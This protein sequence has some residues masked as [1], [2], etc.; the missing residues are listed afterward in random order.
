MSSSTLH[1]HKFYHRLPLQGQAFGIEEEA[2][3]QQVAYIPV[4]DDYQEIF[5]AGV[6]INIIEEILQ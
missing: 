6:S 5:L 3:F 1:K 2:V 4:A